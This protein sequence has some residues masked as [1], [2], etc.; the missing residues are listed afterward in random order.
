M[1]SIHSSVVRAEQY[2]QPAVASGLVIYPPEREIYSCKKEPHVWPDGG[3]T[4]TNSVAEQLISI[5]PIAARC[6]LAL[7]KTQ[8]KDNVPPW[9]RSASMRYV[10][11]DKRYIHFHQRSWRYGW[12]TPLLEVELVEQRSLGTETYNVKTNVNKNEYSKLAISAV[13]HAE[14][15]V[16]AMVVQ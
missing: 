10:Y 7:K 15:T 12:S 13:G 5:C 14:A 3:S 4:V 2:W 16:K 8:P 6:I 1:G 11:G 9:P